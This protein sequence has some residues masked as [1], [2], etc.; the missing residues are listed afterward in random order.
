MSN[1]TVTTN[2]G[3]K[4]SKVSGDPDKLV[5]GSE[6]TTEFTNIATAVATKADTA[7]PTITGTL[8]VATVNNSGGVAL[9]F[10]TNTKLAT[11]SSGIA[12]TGGITST[13]HIDVE[14]NTELRMGID[15]DFV[16][17][18]GGTNSI[19]KNDTGSLKVLS[20]SIFIKNNADN[21]FILTGAADGAVEIYYDNGKKIETLS[22]GAKVYGSLISSNKVGVGVDAPDKPLHIYNA[23]TDVVGR[24]E[25]GDSTAGIEFLDNTLG[26]SSTAQIKNDQGVLSIV[27]DQGNAIADSRIDLN[28]DNT[29]EVRVDSNGLNVVSGHTEINGVTITAGNGTP[30]GVVTA[31][32]GSLFLR[33]NGGAGSSFYVKESGTGNTGWVAK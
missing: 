12:V 29:V 20:D 18:H 16:L 1:Y 10:N 28:V 5:K 22:N 27:T 24:F 4:D 14:D 23:V 17:Y 25:S 21:E 33:K 13:G 32:V 30:E 8:T 9:Q 7:S 3:A 19:I 31:P 2:F 11:T 6:F 15:D 26:T